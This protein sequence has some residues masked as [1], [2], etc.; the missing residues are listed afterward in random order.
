MPEV[1]EKQ[2]VG[3]PLGIA[4]LVRFSRHALAMLAEV[5]EEIDALNVYPVPDGD[6]GTNL[7]LTFEA[8]DQALKDS[9]AAKQP[10]QG[11]A[12]A[13]TL[14]AYCRGLMLGARG[15]SGVIMS[16]LVGA[17]LR[18]IAAA[19]LEEP[20]ATVL[21][22]GMA[23]ATEAAYTAV[24][25]PV[26]GTM[27]TVARAASEAASAAVSDTH[28][29]VEV[30]VAAAG[31]AARSALARTPELLPVLRHAGVVDAGGR[32]LCVVLEAGEAVVFGRPP[33]SSSRRSRSSRPAPV[34]VPEEDLTEDGPAYEVMYL[35]EA[36]DEAIPHLR[37][38]LTPLGDSLVVVGG[39]RLWNVHVHVDDVGAA[40]EAGIAAG[41][42]HRIRVT[43]FAEQL[44]RVRR[45]SAG[46]SARWAE[47]RHGRAVVAYA[48][49]SGLA[50]LFTD[51]GAAVVDSSVAQ[52]PST[53]EILAAIR[54]TGAHEV[55]VLPN[56]RDVVPIAEAAAG[57]AQQDEGLHVAVV[58]TDAQVQGIAAL[59]VHDPARPF[60]QDLVEMV[61]A[62]RHARS[63]A[64]TIAARRAITTGGECLPGDVLGA[65]EGDFVVVGQDQATVAVEVLTRLLGGG[66]ELVTVITGAGGEE[67]TRRCV[68]H[69]RTHYP[70][71]G[72]TVYEG[73][74]E[75]YP[76]LV[77]VE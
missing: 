57:L 33:R 56:D 77:G 14:A 44:A 16:Q 11:A 4:P 8:G 20:P 47:P 6:T 9:L 75:R 59:A 34:P 19:D 12:V 24:G 60:E 37:R 17:L 42:P 36:D 65:V 27:L 49:G 10:E 55:V 26:E 50:G 67:L 70:L 40:I 7:Y 51:A 3:E 74:Q 35:L 69:L 63:G 23:A 54:A 66:G 29:G 53:G 15:N 1:P 13:A 39:E 61:A 43:H 38:R 48:F 68:E 76:L 32:G 2:E 58:P 30:V 72:V 28:A 64:V 21:A 62:A 31:A 22:D 25:D 46:E 73:G 71:V 5:R 18:R 52:R 41:R 45:Q